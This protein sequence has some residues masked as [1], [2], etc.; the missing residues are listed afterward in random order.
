MAHSPKAA[1]TSHA[2]LATAS[3]L[4]RA[5]ARAAW[6]RASRPALHLWPR[7]FCKDIVSDPG[8]R[9]TPPLATHG[10]QSSVT[11][12][13]MPFVAWFVSVLDRSSGGTLS[14]VSQRL[15]SV[16][17]TQETLLNG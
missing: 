14:S 1:W 10:C 6:A 9:P 16:R 11:S 4:L 5:L 17:G 7:P 15:P 13:T 8:R 2:D 12:S 3:V